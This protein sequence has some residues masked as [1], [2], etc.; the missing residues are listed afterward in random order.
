MGTME[1]S[2]TPPRAA[3]WAVASVAVL[4]HAWCLALPFQAD[5]YILLRQSPSAI[6]LAA[7]PP[8]L[9]GVSGDLLDNTYLFR[10]VTWFLW[11]LLTLL[12]G[13][14]ASAPLFHAAS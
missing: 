11:W 2:R 10:P 13:G 9:P 14:I 3:L 8:P 1:E 4:F 7:P 6:G 5:D 12:G